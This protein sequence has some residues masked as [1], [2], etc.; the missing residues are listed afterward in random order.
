ML[1]RFYCCITLILI[2]SSKI[3]SQGCSILQSTSSG[4]PFIIPDIPLANATWNGA[5]RE[6]ILINQANSICSLFTADNCCPTL[7]G[8]LSGS[9]TCNNAP[10][11]LTF[12]S[13]SGQGPFTLVYSDGVQAYTQSN[14]QDGIPFS[15]QVQP[16]TTTVYNLVSIQD[17]TSSCGATMVPAGITATINPGNCSLCQGALGDPVINVT[18]GAG[19]GNSPPLETAV[20]GAS[21]TNLTYVPVSG[22]PAM[23]TPV[24]GQY[25][26]TN[27]VPDHGGNAWFSAGLDHTPGDING[28]MLFENASITPG[29]F[30]R[31]KVSNLC[32]SI[33][34][35][36]AAWIANAVNPAT[37]NAI[38]PDL[39]FIV[40]TEDG[41]VLDTY[42][43]G[44]VPQFA[45]WTWQQYGFFFT[46]PAGIGNVIVRIINNNPGGNV[47]PGNDFAIDDITFRACGPATTASFSATLS[48]S[49]LTVCEGSGGTLYGNISGGYANPEYF[50]QISQDSG[51][52]WMDLPSSGSLQQTV[53]SPVTGRSIDYRYRM[54][55][56]DGNNIQSP[57][58][59]I[60]S[61]EVILSVIPTPNADF[62]FTQDICSP[63]QVQFAGVTQ[64]TDTYTWNIEGSDH[65][66]ATS[67][68]PSLSY[69]FTS[70]GIYP[71][72]LK[73]AGSTCSNSL[74]KT[75]A[76]Q[77]QPANIIVTSDTTIC[78]GKAVPLH[79]N[80]SLDF[81]WSPT[82]YLDNPASSNPVANPP[83]M[84]KY[85]FTTKT[86][87]AN[88]IINGDF[89]AGNSGFTSDYPYS[90]SGLPAAVYFIGTNPANWN[91][92][93]SSCSDHTTGSGNMLLVNGSEQLNTNIWAETITV[94]P[95]TNYAFSAWLQSISNI[96]PAILQ[97]SINGNPLSSQL[98]ASPTPCEWNQFYTTWNSGNTTTAVISIINENQSFSGNDFALDDISF[99]PVNV[100]IDSVT[101]SVETPSVKAAPADTIV[102]PGTPALLHATGS[103]NYAWSPA[104]GLSDVAIADPVALI[105][106]S[107]PATVTYTVTGTS[108]RGCVASDQVTVNLFPRLLTIGADTTICR[109]DPARLNASGAVFYSWS[110]AQYLD[111]PLSLTP[112]SHPDRTTR[113]YLWTTDINQ[114]RET[115]SVTVNVRPVP[116][117]HAPPDKIICYG[118]ETTLESS[119]G[120]DYVYSWVPATGLDDPSSPAPDTRPEATLTYTLH[121]ND[122]TCTAYDSSFSVEVVVRPNPV[123]TAEK[124][125]D[126]DCAV[127][128]AQLRA[129]GGVS[130][131][132]QPVSGLNNP[133]SP[134]PIASVDTTTTYV[135]RGTGS[136]GCYAYDTLT[137]YVTATGANTFV[138]PNAFTPN[139]DG[140]N[141]CF[142]VARWGDIQLEELMIYDRWG[143]RVFSTRN[144]SECWD[145]TYQG[146][147]QPMGT[148]V[149]IIKAR[150]Y[151]GEITRK[152]TLMLV[153]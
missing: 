21:S 20:P 110:P 46:L 25:T 76:I 39:T 115:D 128:A 7:Q 122:S 52:T 84:T 54:L 13:L 120:P 125:N 63:M 29:E 18:F 132:W 49:L 151:C 59:R 81:C 5:L 26:I 66:A 22:N 130:Y 91:P 61:N 8:T 48:S 97:F 150:T 33:T 114:C 11:L 27:N 3:Y 62:S 19:N 6:T 145:G 148:Y 123:I 53:A 85:Y 77:V 139:G 78:V 71:V 143:M 94:Q 34:Y 83:A 86:T 4:V 100:Q 43:S 126:I 80:A 65:I 142:G 9:N 23:P 104:T 31:E 47:L 14:V 72:T 88:L 137:V 116:V 42:N 2:F 103:L 17:N 96:S 28:Y 55:V 79:A 82:A 50:W 113:F 36:F 108:A 102:C 68:D 12:H 24:D 15:V 121:I 92:G 146:R 10:G 40:Q 60:A 117:F 35:E 111:N 133:Y 30:F 98:Q 32:G 135:V 147:Q 118:F 119:N 138:V 134:A 107:G 140:H 131:Q 136:N 64:P 74:S 124:N 99:A 106:A 144:P 70:F 87:G 1:I 105:P 56:A 38:N 89:A 51:K 95:N 16:A 141:D 129:D 57:N 73:V 101:I 109:G 93:M 149:Y 112:I 41:T 69:T 37:L 127:H 67:G 90:S 45:T 153:R 75:I 58:C 44:P 152:G